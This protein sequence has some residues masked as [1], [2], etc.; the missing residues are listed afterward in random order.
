MNKNLKPIFNLQGIDANP[1][2][3]IFDDKYE[4]VKKTLLTD[5]CK[6]K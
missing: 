5:F 1:Q 6:I 2:K 4:N 3:M